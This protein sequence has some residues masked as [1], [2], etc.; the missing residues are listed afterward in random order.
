M[1][2]ELMDSESMDVVMRLD[3][4]PETPSIAIARKSDP[5]TLVTDPP[6]ERIE[7]MLPFILDSW[8]RVKFESGAGCARA[9]YNE[10]RGYGLLQKPY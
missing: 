4:Q 9:V 5:H 7:K 8:V 1:V 2:S 6:M 10:I 3:A